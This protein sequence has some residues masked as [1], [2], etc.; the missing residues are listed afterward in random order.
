MVAGTVVVAPPGSL[1][2]GP[3]RFWHQDADGLAYIEYDASLATKVGSGICQVRPGTPLGAFVGTPL[4][5]SDT[6]V[7]DL[8]FSCLGVNN[9]EPIVVALEDLALNATFHW[10]PGVQAG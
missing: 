6:P 8:S 3:T 2:N 1:A 10:F 5:I 7:G 9:S 4:G